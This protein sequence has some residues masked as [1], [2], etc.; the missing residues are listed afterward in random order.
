MVA[1]DQLIRRLRIFSIRT[2]WN[3][4]PLRGAVLSD[5]CKTLIFGQ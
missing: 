4:V 1:G 5:T 3:T 2:S